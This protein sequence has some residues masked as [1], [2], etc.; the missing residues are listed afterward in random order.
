MNNTHAGWPGSIIDRAIVEKAIGKYL[1]THRG[2]G[3]KLLD[4]LRS[5]PADRTESEFAAEIAAAEAAREHRIETEL[6]NING[7]RI[8]AGL[9]PLDKNFNEIESGE[10][11]KK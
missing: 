1:R 9:R 4:W 3:Q 2:G 11:P 5:D 7:R 8:K 10:N 6:W